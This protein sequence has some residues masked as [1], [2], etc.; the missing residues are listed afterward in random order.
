MTKNVLVITL[1]VHLEKNHLIVVKNDTK[2]NK[3]ED[4]YLASADNK[5]NKLA[6]YCDQQPSTSN[7]VYISINY[8]ERVFV[9]FCFL[10][11]KIHLI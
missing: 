8:F 10:Q 7:N 3:K 5:Q 9:C 4:K 6:D 1:Y 2:S 11:N